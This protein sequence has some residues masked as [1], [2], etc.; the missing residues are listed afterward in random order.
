MGGQAATFSPCSP[1]EAVERVLKAHDSSSVLQI[2]RVML[3][4][5]D[6]AGQVHVAAKCRKHWSKLVHPDTCKH[7]RATSAGS[8]AAPH[9][10]APMLP[11]ARQRKTYAALGVRGL[12]RATVPGR[13]RS[14]HAL[15]M[16]SKNALPKNNQ[17]VGR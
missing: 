6:T 4:G 5:L 13:S 7:A 2:R 14:P 12:T 10:E 11:I 1:E 15:N 8:D 3:A 16:K 9:A 17:Q